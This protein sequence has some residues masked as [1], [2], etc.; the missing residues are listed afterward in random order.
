MSDALEN[1]QLLDNSIELEIRER[2]REHQAAV[3]RIKSA[4]EYR[5]A[6]GKKIPL[7]SDPLCFLA[8]GDSWFNYPLWGNS[9]S[10]G[11]TDIIRQLQP[12]GNP[13]PL[14]LNVS[15]WGDSTTDEMSLPKQARMIEAI[16]D[17][18]NWLND[19]RLPD[20]ILFSGGG[21]D[22][23]GEQFVIFLNYNIGGTPLNSV[24]FKKKLEEI[25]ASHL[26]LFAFRDRFA[27][28]VP[29]FGHS[30]DFPIP[31]GVHPICVGPWLKPSFDFCGWSDIAVTTKT[32]KDA[33][34]DFNTMLVA[35]S[36]VS[37]YK[38]F[39]AHTQGTLKPDD[40]ANELHPYPSGFIELA[41]KFLTVLRLYPQF[42]NRI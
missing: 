16:E 19:A 41:K 11:T 32:V 5:K 14:I 4:R 28:N 31:N 17:P 34:T 24:R 2:T 29:I 21:N 7:A 36:N 40:W 33:L 38:F 20:G 26:D 25:E 9:I 23:A 42:H 30:Y 6:K 12:L 10:L 18:A 8:H 1:R 37:K 15:H 3:A 35:L 22:I 39:L 13:I 27:P